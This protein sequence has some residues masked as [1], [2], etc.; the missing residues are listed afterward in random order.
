MLNLGEDYKKVTWQKAAKGILEY[1]EKQLRHYSG[2][3]TLRDTA[4]NLKISLGA[5]SEYLKLGRALRVHYELE[6]M[7][8]K[9]ATKWIREKGWS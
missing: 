7:G 1:H 8:R 2:D 4:E 3:W 5:V 9:A 6:N